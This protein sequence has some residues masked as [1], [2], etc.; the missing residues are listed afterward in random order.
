MVYGR[1]CVGVC[2]CV[3]S[4][5]RGRGLQFGAE[6]IKSN[7]EWNSVAGVCGRAQWSGPAAITNSRQNKDILY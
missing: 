5:L 3:P 6:R 7:R 1:V 4:G 2:M